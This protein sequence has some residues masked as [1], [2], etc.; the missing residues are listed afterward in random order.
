MDR[1]TVPTAQ[2]AG[3]G[4]KARLT[5]VGIAHMKFTKL[6]G[7]RP[8]AGKAK[9]GFQGSLTIYG[10]SE[11]KAL[12]VDAIG[13]CSE[14][15]IDLQGLEEFDA[16]GIQLLLSVRSP[17]TTSDTGDTRTLKLSNPPPEFRESLEVVGL[18]DTLG[19]AA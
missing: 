10:I 11:A 9:L 5:V 19:V 1:Q 8:S 6:R 3:R 14:I 18:I 15:E 12:L 17:S 7:N 16:S 2:A 4:V 13:D